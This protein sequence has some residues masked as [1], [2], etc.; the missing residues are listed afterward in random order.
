MEAT[1]DWSQETPCWWRSSTEVRVTVCYCSD[2]CYVIRV[3]FP[4]QI[5]VSSRAWMKLGAWSWENAVYSSSTNTQQVQKC[6]YLN[7]K[8]T[9][10]I[11]EC[12]FKTD[13]WEHCCFCLTA[14]S[15]VKPNS[16]KSSLT[17]HNAYKHCNE[18]IRSHNKT[19]IP[20]NSEA[21]IFY[22]I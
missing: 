18:P 16:K 1:I 2:M 19:L 21:Y 12:V 7:L 13:Y 11:E 5:S 22:L 6:L 9:A 4:A 15:V 8:K 14:T 10:V 20:V 17:N 3:E